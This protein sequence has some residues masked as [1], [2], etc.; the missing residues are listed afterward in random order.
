MATWSIRAEKSVERD[1][2]IFPPGANI[3][4]GILQMNSNRRKNDNEGTFSGC[5]GP[6]LLLSNSVVRLSVLPSGPRAG[7][8]R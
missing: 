4:P 6:V 7:H 8:F 5:L 1:P 2:E 3:R